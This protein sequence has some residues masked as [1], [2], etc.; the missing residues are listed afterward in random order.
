[1]SDL[2]SDVA[3]PVLESSPGKSLIT[4][5]ELLRQQVGQLCQ[6]VRGLVQLISVLDKKV[7]T[8]LK[9]GYGADCGVL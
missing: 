2:I 7:D 6:A 3:K 9:G 1:M 4:E 8:V 5:V